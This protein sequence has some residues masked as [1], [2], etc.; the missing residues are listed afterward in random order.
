MAAIAPIDHSRWP[1]GGASR[2]HAW[3]EPGQFARLTVTFIQDKEGSA[4][5]RLP[6]GSKTTVAYDVLR[7]A[8]GVVHFVD[9]SAHCGQCD[10]EALATGSRTEAEDRFLSHFAE[11]HQTTA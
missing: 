11:A 10:W 8:G 5:V 7:P 4:V 9:D 3:V 1:S 6:N 2:H